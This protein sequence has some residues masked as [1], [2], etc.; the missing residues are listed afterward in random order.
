MYGTIGGL[1]LDESAPGWKAFR[2]RPSP[3][4]GLTSAKATLD[5]PYGVIGSDW[6]I[7]GGTFTLAVTVPVNTT[8]TVYLPYPGSVKVDGAT[9]PA[10][11]AE[12]GYPLA[13]GTYVFT[14]PTP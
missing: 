5:S 13:S 10:P 12:G 1:E 2:V 14:V 9:P 3:G 4:G 8:A 11:N 7:A 6:K